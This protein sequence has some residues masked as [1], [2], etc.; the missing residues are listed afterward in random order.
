ME[1]YLPKMSLEAEIE[2]EK[3]ILLLT[4]GSEDAKRRIRKIVDCL[5][6]QD[7]LIQRMFKKL[8][9]QELI[10]QG[11][12]EE[13]NRRRTWIERLKMWLG[14]PVT[15]TLIVNHTEEEDE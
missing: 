5:F 3:T 15:L 12:T 9:D 10:I 7:V 8:G 4:D 13:L 11:L 2:L 14:I 1:E 6:N